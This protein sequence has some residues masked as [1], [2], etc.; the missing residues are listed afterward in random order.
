MEVLSGNGGVCLEPLNLP[1]HSTVRAMRLATHSSNVLTTTANTLNRKSLITVE[2]NGAGVGGWEERERER[3][4]E[5]TKACIEAERF[6]L[7]LILW[8]TSS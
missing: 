1:T 3:E 2:S 7:N 8:N 5:Y 6:W 4:R